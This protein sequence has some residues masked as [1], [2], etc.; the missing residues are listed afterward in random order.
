MTL[1]HRWYWFLRALR[2]RA[3]ATVTIDATGRVFIDK[4]DPGESVSVNLETLRRLQ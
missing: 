4:L 3:R 1:R 2:L